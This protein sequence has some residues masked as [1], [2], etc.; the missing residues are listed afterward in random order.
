M[1]GRI[2]RRIVA[3]IASGLF[4][5]LGL[6]MLIV[7]LDQKT[8]LWAE[9]ELTLYAPVE[10]TSFFNLT[11]V[12]NPFNLFVDFGTAGNWQRW[13]LSA[14]LLLIIGWLARLSPLQAWLKVISLGLILG[15]AIGNLVD[16]IRVGRV[17]DFLDFHYAGLHW[18]AFNIADVAITVG[19]LLL[20]IVLLAERFPDHSSRKS[21]D[22]ES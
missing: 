8:K 12:Y 14:V 19:V 1:I 21:A 10:V 9:A 2:A 13:A 16:V 6:A 22:S 17:V 20:I 18:P 4:P 5:G 7:W 15:G 11:L 3:W